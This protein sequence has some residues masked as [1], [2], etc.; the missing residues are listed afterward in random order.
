M[1]IGIGIE[2]SNM[3][4]AVTRREEPYYNETPTRIARGE[5][6]C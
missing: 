1:T 5:Q 4:S 2:T 3:D 6:C